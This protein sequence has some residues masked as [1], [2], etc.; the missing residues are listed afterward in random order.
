MVIDF[1][2]Q[3]EKVGDRYE[4]QVF[5]LLEPELL[6]H[7]LLEQELR[8]VDTLLLVAVVPVKV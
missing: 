3:R 1:N 4:V 8:F 2:D 7:L 5:D 6:L